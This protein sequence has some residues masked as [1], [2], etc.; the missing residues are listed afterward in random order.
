M[1]EYCTLSLLVSNT[2]Y[3]QESFKVQDL[4]ILGQLTN[5]KLAFMDEENNPIILFDAKDLETN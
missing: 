2:K 3:K 4:I 5:T 1:I